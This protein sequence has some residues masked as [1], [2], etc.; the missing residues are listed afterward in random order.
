M[1]EAY[2]LAQ[3]LVKKAGARVGSLSKAARGYLLAGK[4]L[5]EPFTQMHYV[6]IHSEHNVGQALYR[7]LESGLRH[8]Q[9]NEACLDFQ[10]SVRAVQGMADGMQM[11]RVVLEQLIENGVGERRLLTGI[12]QITA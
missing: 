5:L 1:T 11:V 8:W 12:S 7:S 6:P 2:Q 9:H 4:S 10:P 3:N